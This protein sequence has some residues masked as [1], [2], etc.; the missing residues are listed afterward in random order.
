MHFIDDDNKEA[1]YPSKVLGFI[2]TANGVE[3]VIQCASKPL[4][5]AAVEN[6]MFVAFDLGHTMASFV[7]VPLESFV[8][9]L[10]VFKDYSGP[11]NR[12][13]VVLPT[14]GWVQY[15]GSDMN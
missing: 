11:R 10:C 3:A 8:Y 15:F 2:D 14:R 12:Y 5:W 9:L 13:I 4:K 7:L 6:K 1:Y